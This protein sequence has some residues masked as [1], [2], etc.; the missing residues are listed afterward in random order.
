MEIVIGLFFNNTRFIID[1]KS[2]FEVESVIV[3]DLDFGFARELCGFWNE[4]LFVSYRSL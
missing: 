2:N 1:L 4:K 3:V